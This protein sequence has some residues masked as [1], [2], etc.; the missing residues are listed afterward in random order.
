[1]FQTLYYA[2]ILNKNANHAEYADKHIDTADFSE[3]ENLKSVNDGRSAHRA[4]T[5]CVVLQLGPAR[6]AEEEEPIFTPDDILNPTRLV[7]AEGKNGVTVSKRSFFL[8]AAPKMRNGDRDRDDDGGDDGQK[9]NY[10]IALFRV[11]RGD[12]TLYKNLRPSRILNWVREE[13]LAFRAVYNT[14]TIHTASVIFYA[15]LGCAT[16]MTCDWATEAGMTRSWIQ[17]H[18]C[19]TTPTS[20]W[21]ETDLAIFKQISD[22]LDRPAALQRV[23]DRLPKDME[24]GDMHHAVCDIIT[25]ATE[26]VYTTTSKRPLHALITPGADNDDDVITVAQRVG[27]AVSEFTNRRLVLIDADEIAAISLVSALTQQHATDE[28]III[29][30]A[31]KPEQLKSVAD[32]IAAGAKVPPVIV[33]TSTEAHTAL[34]GAYP[35]LEHSLFNVAV[36]HAPPPPQPD[37]QLLLPHTPARRKRL[38]QRNTPASLTQSEKKVRRAFLH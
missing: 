31:A 14:V 37:L 28:V 29:A 8:T 18:I 26:R 30:K 33:V 12:G 7:A 3:I 4:N 36:T 9:C 20:T 21:H 25:M 27:A 23:A 16:A 19:Q 13:V 34:Y 35:L 2:D 5:F 10:T 1:M 38:L 15:C 24:H 6:T 32:A 22:V 11:R 17:A